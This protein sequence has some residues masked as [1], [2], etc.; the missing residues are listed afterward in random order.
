MTDTQVL[1]G[2]LVLL[3]LSDAVVWI[4][5]VGVL[6]YQG[7]AGAF[8]H[9]GSSPFGNING[10]LFLLNPLPWNVAYFAYWTPLSLSPT[11][12]CNFGIPCP[13]RAV[14]H[15]ASRD[16]LPFQRIASVTAEEK[17]LL[18][19]GRVFSKCGTPREAR[20]LA[21]LI[22][23]LGALGEDQRAKAISDHL[24]STLSYSDARRRHALVQQAA[25]PVRLF[26]S[27]FFALLFVVTPLLA[28]FLSLPAALWSLLASTLVGVGAITVAYFRADRVLN[29]KRRLERIGNVVK[30]IFC[31]PVA[32]RATDLLTLDSMADFH[33]LLVAAV[34]FESKPTAFYGEVIRDCLH[35]LPLKNT[36]PAAAATATWYSA[37]QRE[38]V[39]VFFK[40]QFPQAHEQIVRAPKGDGI[41]RSYCPRCL[42]QFTRVDGPCSD[43]AGVGL[44]EIPK[45]TVLP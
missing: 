10:G 12:I 26:A 30:M 4:R 21:R 32:I 43:C 29:P 42:S 27:I 13:G 28:V 34:L 36:E 16:W 19:N 22:T 44:I 33:P 45:E 3:Y 38:A 39:T 1:C 6:F 18:I 23:R 15:S 11:G 9:R 2:I 20:Q 14:F 24:A 17:N 35:P 8:S 41:A 7:W 25:A 37:A 31:P 40:A 5:S